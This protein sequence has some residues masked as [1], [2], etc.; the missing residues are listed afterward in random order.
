MVLCALVGV[1]LGLGAYTFL[2]AEGRLVVVVLARSPGCLSPDVLPG[3]IVVT[4]SG[5]GAA[6]R[7]Q[8]A[9]RVTILP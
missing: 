1:M 6:G 2:Y 9:K 4:L 3:A 8:R 7:A 5:V